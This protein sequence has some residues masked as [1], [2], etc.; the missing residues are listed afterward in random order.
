MKKKLLVS[1]IAVVLVLALSVGIFAA[2]NKNNNDGNSSESEAVDLRVNFDSKISGGGASGG[3]VTANLDLTLADEEDHS[4]DEEYPI[5]SSALGDFYKYYVAA[6][7]Q[8][9]VDAKHAAQALAEAK[10]LESGTLL[11]TTAQGGRYGLTKV[12]PYTASTV[13]WGTDSD[14]LY[15]LLVANEMIKAADRDALKALYAEK[16]GSGTYIAEAKKYLAAHGYTLKR[17]YSLG[18]SA[19]P[20]TWDITNTYRSAD[21]QWIVNTYDGLVGYDVEGRLMGMLAEDLTISAD[22]L[23]YTFKIREGVKWVDQ[24][25]REYAEVQADDFVYG[26]QR[27]LD[28]GATSYLVDGILKGAT[29]YMADEDQDFSHVGVKAVSKYV[30]EYELE[31]PCDFFIT[32]FNYNTF[33]PACREYA[34]A[35]EGYGTAPDKILYNGPYIISNYTPNNKF[36]FSKNEKY[37][38]A[39]AINV[40]T[41]N[42]LSYANNDDATATYSDFKAGT[43]DGVGLNTSTVEMAKTDNLFNDYA[44][45]SG[46][47]STAFSFFVNINRAAFETESF[48]EDTSAKTEAQKDLAK[49]ALSNANFRMA[50]ARGIDRAAYNALSVGEDCKNY[51]LI[52]T[53]VPG[54]FVALGK[55]V[56]IEINGVAKTFAKGTYYGEIIQAQHDPDMGEYAIKAWDPQADGGI[57]SSAGFDGWFSASAAQH[58]LELAIA[59]LEDDGFEV[60]A[61]NPIVIDYPVYYT[62][63]VYKR[64]AEALKQRIGEVFGGKVVLNIVK[65]SSPDSWYSVG[66]YC[67]S[68]AECNYDIY[69]CSGWGPDYGDPQTYLNTMN[70]VTGDMIKMLGIY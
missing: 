14:R 55:D 41:I 27:I 28:N 58:Y 59:E 16:K 52:N 8:D 48:P 50:F 6:Q 68:G 9:D 38:N 21:S 4:S 47:D 70:P 64:R 62:Y 31:A 7:D 39:G 61:E 33:A 1:F 57:G 42:V 35:T 13:G 12:A 19:D 24:N 3:A 43:I 36:V 15:T 53:Y 5:Y 26:M 66:Y 30:L 60:S 32:M 45:V 44:Y 22:G 2:C 17:T 29:A 46:T 20:R 10:L 69:D 67:E 63:E 51:S 49:A 34:E 11:P 23:K 25:G 54:T 37:W 18:N 56:T 40:D 65:C